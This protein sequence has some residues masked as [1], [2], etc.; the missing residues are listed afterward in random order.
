MALMN[1]PRHEFSFHLAYP[2]F[3]LCYQLR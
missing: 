1:H 2:A 3:D